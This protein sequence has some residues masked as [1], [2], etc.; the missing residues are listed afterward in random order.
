M[1]TNCDQIQ[2]AFACKRYMW[3]TTCEYLVWLYCRVVSMASFADQYERFG[4]E[5]DDNAGSAAPRCGI[6]RQ[7]CP[8]TWV[9]ETV[10]SILPA[11]ISGL[12][13]SGTAI[14]GVQGAPSGW[15][16]CPD[17]RQPNDD[18]MYSGFSFRP[19]APSQNTSGYAVFA[20]KPGSSDALVTRMA[21]H[22]NEKQISVTRAITNID[23][24]NTFAFGDS[25]VFLGSVHCCAWSSVKLTW[26]T[27][28]PASLAEVLML[29]IPNDHVTSEYSANHAPFVLWHPSCAKESD[30]KNLAKVTNLCGSLHMNGPVYLQ[31]PG[32]RCGIAA[33][34]GCKPSLTATKSCKTACGKKKK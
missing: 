25:A 31:I 15:V 9:Q 32:K 16:F 33:T 30:R 11:E 22:F 27:P 18:T 1:R 4:N 8:P 23:V 7:I 6:S 24:L 28:Y 10:R 34:G 5:F 17:T 2:V 26:A 3:H 19:R 14:Q 29:E 20:T 13:Q 21:A 12:V